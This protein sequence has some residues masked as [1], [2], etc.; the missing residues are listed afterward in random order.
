MMTSRKRITERLELGPRGFAIV[1]EAGELWVLEGYEPDDDL[2]G[3][4]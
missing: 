2:I 3:P 1:T 4:R